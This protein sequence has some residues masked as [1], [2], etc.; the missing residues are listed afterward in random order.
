MKTYKRLAALLGVALTLASGG[1]SAHAVPPGEIVVAGEVVM[2]LR[3]GSGRYSLEE[4]GALVQQRLVEML[5]IND[6]NTNDVA[7]RASK[8]GP[9]IYVRGQK[10]I[11]IDPP[12]A[13]AAG[14]T[15]DALARVW[16][17]R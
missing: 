3:V 5:S 11:T 4:R 6:L 14:L 16:S 7:V 15:P 10:L 1:R 2:R 9:T 17:Q 12:T 13:E 8:F